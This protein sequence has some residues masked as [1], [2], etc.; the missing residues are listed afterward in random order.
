MHS[1]QA[2][3]HARSF[4]AGVAVSPDC[5][6]GLDPLHRGGAPW[7]CIPDGAPQHR[8]EEQSPMPTGLPSAETLFDSFADAAYLID[9]ETSDIVWANRCA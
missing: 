1:S 8:T 4:V 6:G 3:R 7:Q 9:P 5:S 2:V